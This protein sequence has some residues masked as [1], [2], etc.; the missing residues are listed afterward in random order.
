M[1]SD[2]GFEIHMFVCL[3]V[4]SRCRFGGSLSKMRA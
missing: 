3:T 2:G 1:P 4:V